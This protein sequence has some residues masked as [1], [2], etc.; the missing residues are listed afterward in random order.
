[1]QS[2]LAQTLTT[3]QTGSSGQTHTRGQTKPADQALT[4]PR[5]DQPDPFAQRVWNK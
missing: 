2:F 5:V 3:T 1:M 4:P